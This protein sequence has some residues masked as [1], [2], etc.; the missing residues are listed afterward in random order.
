MAT[1][2]SSARPDDEVMELDDSGAVD[3]V[4]VGT[5]AANLAKARRAGLPALPGFVIPAAVVASLDTTTALPPAVLHAY[6]ELSDRGTRAVV[7]RSSS[8]SEDTD[9]SS[10]AGQFT[11]VVGVM[12]ARAFV[13]AVGD[14]AGSANGEPM[15]VLVQPHLDPAV[16]GVAFGV[17]PVSGRADR[18]VVAAVQGGPQ[19]LVSGAVAGDRYELT[20]RGRTVTA[21]HDD[22]GTDL[23]RQERR[24]VVRLASAAAATFGGPQDVEWAITG[25]GEVVLLQSR[26]VT[27]RTSPPVGPRYGQGPLAETFPAPLSRLEQDL[28]LP[29]LRTA[30]A[31]VAVLTGRASRRRVARGAVV[32]APGGRPAIDMDLLGEIRP[33]GL[34]AALDPRPRLRRL[35]AAWRVGRLAAASAA[36][37]VDTVAD[38]D[39]ALEAVPELDGLD[40][41]ALLAVLDR[42]GAALTSL[43]GHEVLAGALGGDDVGPTGAE[44]AL[45]ALAKARAD[46]VSDAVA[47]GR[48]P[49]V[50]ALSAPGIGVP[51][52]LPA[53]APVL[54]PVSVEDLGPRESLRL[55]T[56]WVH[57]LTARVAAELGRRLVARGRLTD[58]GDVR[59][60]TKDA[61]DDAVH[62]RP[63]SLTP[64]RAGPP[65]PTLFRLAVDG[66][67]VA[68]DAPRGGAGVGAG[69]GRGAGPVHHGDE[70]PPGSVLVV[71]VLDPRLAPWLPR[72]AGL[73]AETGS[74]LSHLAILA[75]EHGVATVVGVPG[76]LHR[77]DVGDVVVVDGV[78]GAVATL[79]E[80]DTDR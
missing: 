64:S 25:D 43:H 4:A 42:A 60:L 62:G 77:W 48:H 53:D 6:R 16:S 74:P 35:G 58:A 32:V 61:L 75:R 19:A 45:H 76:A 67:V 26:P 55:R 71:D 65:L 24:A 52:P 69:G 22:G 50:L 49:E 38:A 73:V 70:P 18:R 7:V 12:G 41:D 10:H 1:W 51:E 47:R 34:I 63:F 20:P 59:H 2:L 14:V 79:H 5:K 17:D 40:D 27:A 29:P 57:E 68:A 8:S 9:A 28:W 15:A 3:A 11:S 13:D 33:S 56:R 31:E 54:R 46:G 78:T 37:A 23:G 39:R 66:T 21:V 36:L 80:Q 30:L 72:L 44:V